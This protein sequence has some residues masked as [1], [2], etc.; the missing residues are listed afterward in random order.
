MAAL[1]NFKARTINPESQPLPHGGVVGLILVPSRTTGKGKWVLRYTSP[2]TRKRRNAGLGSFPEV[3]VA[4]AGRLGSEFWAKLKNGVDPLDVKQE[5]ARQKK[6]IPTFYQAANT[7]HGELIDGWANKKHVKD[8]I[9]SLTQY[10][11]PT[12]GSIPINKITPNDIAVTLRPIWL[13]IPETA[14]RVKQRIHSVF[15]WAWAQGYCQSNPVDVVTHL[16]PK[17]PELSVRRKHMRSLPWVDVPHFVISHLHNS[18]TRDVSRLM[19]E[20]LILTAARSGEIRGM[21]WA[22]VDWTDKI[23]VIPPERMKA[24]KQHRIPLTPQALN[25]LE[26]VQDLHDE[27]VFPSPVKQTVLSDMAMTQLIRGIYETSYPNLEVPTAHGF[28]SSFRDWCSEN[29]YERDLAERALAHTIK[30]QVEAA[31]HRTDLLEQRRPM[32]QAWADFVSGTLKNDVHETR[33][34]QSAQIIANKLIKS[35]NEFDLSQQAGKETKSSTVYDNS[36]VSPTVQDIDLAD[37]ERNESEKADA[38]PLSVKKLQH[39]LD[40]SYRDT[41]FATLELN[42]ALQLLVLTGVDAQTL[43]GMNWSEFIWEERLWVIPAERS[44]FGKPNCIPLVDEALHRLVVLSENSKSDTVL[45]L[46]EEDIQELLKHIYDQQFSGQDFPRLD[47]LS[48]M[49]SEHYKTSL[50]YKEVVGIAV[51]H[52]N[53]VERKEQPTSKR[54]LIKRRKL[55]SAWVTSIQDMENGLIQLSRPDNNMWSSIRRKALA[56][57]GEDKPEVWLAKKH[58]NQPTESVLA[59][60]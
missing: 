53:K 35:N 26:Q 15:S 16:L 43:L 44:G 60:A 24:H 10:A 38:E 6:S 13:K 28:R 11:F 7:R 58:V 29:G 32:M 14:G 47:V 33:P 17:Q 37:A 2:I 54:L 20:L 36:S 52:P 25:I 50:E 45:E 41:E 39:I 12:I 56:L 30:N 48:N 18:E 9:N 46:V 1:T 4:D 3:S 23:W 40:A 51:P 55:M 5:A 57:I 27:L 19:L 8:W 59:T 31:Y 34:T 21:R 42:L 22:E 49:L